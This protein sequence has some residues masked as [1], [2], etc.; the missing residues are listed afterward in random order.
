MQSI[1]IIVIGIIIKRHF[2]IIGYFSWII[3]AAKLGII[4][5]IVQI[6]TSF[7]FYKDLILNIIE[8]I[9]EKQKEHLV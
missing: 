4:T 1:I 7:I 6:C 5:A 8:K 9:K 2:I 3:L